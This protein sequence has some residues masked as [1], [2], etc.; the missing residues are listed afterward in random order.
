MSYM[1]ILPGHAMYSPL[2][3]NPDTGSIRQ[4]WNVVFDHWFTTISTASQP[5]FNS[6]EWTS[7]FGD[8]IFLS[9]FADE[10]TDKQPESP[11]A[12]LLDQETPRQDTVI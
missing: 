6:S 9:S 3:L 8:S 4:Q 11:P 7:L 10:D 12:C 1:G 2:A 5:D